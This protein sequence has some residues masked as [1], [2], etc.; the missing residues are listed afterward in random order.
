[1]TKMIRTKKQTKSKPEKVHS[2]FSELGSLV[3]AAGLQFTFDIFRDSTKGCGPHC[4]AWERTESKTYCS[5][6]LAAIERGEYKP[7]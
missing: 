7:S 6:H 4:K 1:M 3:E 2:L 5:N